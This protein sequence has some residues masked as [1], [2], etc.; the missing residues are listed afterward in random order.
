MDFDIVLYYKASKGSCNCL[1]ATALLG[2]RQVRVGNE[3][4]Y[5]HFWVH[6]F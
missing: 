6:T 2:H 1:T 4:T 3:T 5:V